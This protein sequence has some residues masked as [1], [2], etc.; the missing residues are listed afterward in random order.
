M[1]VSDLETLRGLADKLA[2]LKSWGL[3]NIDLKLFRE[4]FGDTPFFSAGGWNEKN[5][6]GVL[7]DGSYDALAFGRYFLSTPDL[8]ERWVA[9]HSQ[10]NPTHHFPDSR[11][12]CRR[13]N[14]FE[15]GSMDLFRTGRSD[16]QIIRFGMNGK[17]TQLLQTGKLERQ[18]REIM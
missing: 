2:V 10:S 13:A 6:W 4:I 14:T 11:E 3:P 18:D 8:V 17:K 12:T 1:N 5:C 9:I 16:T 7:E 15:N